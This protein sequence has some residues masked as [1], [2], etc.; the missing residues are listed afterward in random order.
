MEYIKAQEAIFASH[1]STC[2]VAEYEI[3]DHDINIALVQINGRHPK[4][5][6]AMNEKCKMMGF[7]KTG[8]GFVVIENRKL[9]LSE[10]DVI[11]ILPNEKYYWDGCMTL[12][13]PSTPAWTPDQ[14]KILIDEIDS[15]ST[16]LPKVLK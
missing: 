13:V 7:V 16:Q 9:E 12:L 4:E 6:W 10:N 11:L 8:H 2:Q 5:G 3:N 1:D 15:T 14:C